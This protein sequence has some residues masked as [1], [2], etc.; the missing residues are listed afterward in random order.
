[1]GETEMSTK[2]R[3][4]FVPMNESPESLNSNN[5]PK[6]SRKTLLIISGS[7]AVLLIGFLTWQYFANNAEIEELLV[8][9]D[10]MEVEI[11]DLEQELSTMESSIQ[12]QEIEME[13]KDALLEEKSEEVEKLKKQIFKLVAAGKLSEQKALEQ[14]GKIDQLT[15]YIR[16]YQNEIAELKAENEALRNQVASIEGERDSIKSKYSEAKDQNTLYQVKIEGASILKISG[17]T[18]VP[19]KKNGKEQDAG[20]EFKADK[21]E[22]LKI[23]GTVAENTLSK[24][25]RKDFYL[26]IR[27]PDG[28]PQGGG[29]FT[30][31]KQQ[32][33]YTGKQ[34][35]DYQGNATK[36]CFDW[37]PPAGLSKGEYQTIVFA[38]GYEI[39]SSRFTL[40]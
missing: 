27:N 19:V 6:V 39:G 35:V 31:N 29:T 18:F 28:T 2:K 32:M 9:N 15:Y 21:T 25:G 3:C 33:V 1:M 26:L 36:I 8:L 16:K 22:R 17:F 7:I 30:L 40:R 14:Q 20:T 4:N 12:N 37:T 13:K 23:C 11:Q 10:Q 38:E 34:S 5:T 24:K